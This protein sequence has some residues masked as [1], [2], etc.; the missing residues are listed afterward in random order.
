MKKIAVALVFALLISAA[1]AYAAVNFE[2]ER[3]GYEFTADVAY[4]GEVCVAVGDHGQILASSDFV[5]WD[6]C[7][8]N[9]YKMRF[10]YVFWIGNKFIAIATGY[11]YPEGGGYQEINSVYESNDGYQW[12]KVV[13]DE[14]DLI[15]GEICWVLENGDLAFRTNVV[16]LTGHDS[17][18]IYRNYEKIGNAYLPDETIKIKDIDTKGGVELK[19]GYNIIIRDNGEE[20]PLPKETNGAISVPSKG[21]Y[22]DSVE[23]VETELNG[24]PFIIGR[25]DMVNV[26]YPYQPPLLAPYVSYFNMNYY[27]QE[28]LGDDVYWEQIGNYFAAYKKSASSQLYVY[29]CQLNL[30]KTKDFEKPIDG[31][32][33]NEDR[34]VVKLLDSVNAEGEKSYTYLYSRDYNSW[35]ETEGLD[36]L[37]KSVLEYEKVFENNNLTQASKSGQIGWWNLLYDEQNKKT[38]LLSDDIYGIDLNIPFKFREFHEP[39]RFL[40]WEEGDLLCIQDGVVRLTTPKQAFYEAIESTLNKPYVILNDKVLCFDVP[41]EVENDRILVP[42]RFLFEQMG[43]E[44]E[45]DN[46]T[47][48]AT[49]LQESDE[50]AFQINNL[51]ANVNS[52]PQTM[53]VP[54]RLINDKTMIPLRFLS[55]HLGYTVEWDGTNNMA[56]VTQASPQ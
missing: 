30:V 37:P 49:V 55:E 16:E 50:I 35:A 45:W 24:I 41:P 9:E 4:N 39:G 29:D 17:F 51:S 27:F 40:F 47:Q 23:G 36:Q 32:F 31:I 44:V 52:Q 46:D 7:N 38:R 34:C 43:A 2:I 18:E 10:E 20:Y 33:K 11:I 42:M 1:P 26:S 6:Y 19:K 15:G 14:L 12:N 56:I 54:A 28:T 53:D 13:R 48:T 25:R 22:Y 21:L 8:I 5:N 3:V